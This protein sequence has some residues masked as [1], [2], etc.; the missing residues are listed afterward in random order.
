MNKRRKGKKPAGAKAPGKAKKA[1]SLLAQ[2]KAV[3]KGKGNICINF[4][5]KLR[6]AGCYGSE[7]CPGFMGR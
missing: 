6:R 3:Q 1:S 2:K 5:C 7:G 4:K